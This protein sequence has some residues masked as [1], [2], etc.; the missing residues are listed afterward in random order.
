[1]LSFLE[2][3]KMVEGVDLSL[4]SLKMSVKELDVELSIMEDG[5]MIELMKIIVPKESR[6]EGLGS[7]VM[8]RIID[9]ADKSKQIITLTP[10]EDFGGKVSKLIPFYKKFGFVE[11][12]GKNKDFQISQTMYRLPKK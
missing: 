6:G 8:K 2:Y 11:N 5:K 10:S 3:W 7:K 1:M 12:K 9:Y 4:Q